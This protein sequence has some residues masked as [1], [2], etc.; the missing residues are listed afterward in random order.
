MIRL[1]AG[2]AIAALLASCAPLDVIKN[3]VTP[4]KGLEVETEIV[5]GD[6][7]IKTSVTA[8]KETTNTTN[9]ADTITQTYT[10]VHAGKSIW[11]I[12]LLMLSSFAVGWLL[13]PSFRQMVIMT[14][15]A[16]KK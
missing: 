8:K 15:A 5:A 6:K 11:E 16:F 13:M 1:Y 7:A 4:A 10:T 14:R 12:F 9:T 2:I 3:I